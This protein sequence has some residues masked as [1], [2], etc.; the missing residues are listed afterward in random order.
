MSD[1]E[2]VSAETSATARPRQLD[3][4][5]KFLLLL[6]QMHTRLLSG[7][8]HSS[9]PDRDDPPDRGESST[10]DIE[11]T[12]APQ[13]G[14]KALLKAIAQDLNLKDKRG[15]AIEG[16]LAELMNALLKDKLSANALKTKLDQYLR[17]ESVEGLR[18]P[19]VNPLIWNQISAS[20]R[21]RDAGSQKNQSTLVGSTIAMAKAADRAMK[22]YAG[23]SELLALIADAIALAIQCHHEASHVRRLAMKKELHKDYGSVCSTVVGTSEFLSGDL[24]KHTK[25]ITDA[26]KLTKKMRP[27]RL[28]ARMDPSLAGGKTGFSPTSTRAPKIR[29]F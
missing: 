20:M 12:E 1:S 9:E 7:D 19:K 11:A 8:D 3:V 16:E 14:H 18:T 13:G 10:Q 25:D 26:N 17:P 21:T 29:I 24:S 2:N 23:D 22:K 15:P 28:T 27:P 6:E 4:D 5:D